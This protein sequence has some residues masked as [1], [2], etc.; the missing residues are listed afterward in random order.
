MRTLDRHSL[1]AQIEVDATGVCVNP[2]RLIVVLG[3]SVFARG[4]QVEEERW[5][6]LVWVQTNQREPGEGE[7]DLVFP[8]LMRDFD[9]AFALVAI[10]VRDHL[11]SAQAGGPV[12]PTGMFDPE[13]DQPRTRGPLF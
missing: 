1:K 12:L 8:T 9:Q 3:T 11:R 5:T 7:P 6:I 13:S 2:K 10:S 4:V